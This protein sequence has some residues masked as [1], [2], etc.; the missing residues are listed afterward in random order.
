MAQAKH[1]K[2][3]ESKPTPRKVT[4]PVLHKGQPDFEYVYHGADGH[5]LY[6]SQYFSGKPETRQYKNGVWVKSKGPGSML[7]NLH[8]VAKAQTVLIVEDEQTVD[9]LNKALN[10]NPESSL[11]TNKIAVTCNW[12]GPGNRNWDDT[13]TYLSEKE[14]FILPF[15][16]SNEKDFFSQR[17]S[18]KV[19]KEIS[20]HVDAVIVE[21]LNRDGRK[22]KPR[23][24]AMANHL[25]NSV[26]SAIRSFA[27]NLFDPQRK[28][29]DS[30]EFLFIID[31]FEKEA[32]DDEI[33][34]VR[35]IINRLNKKYEFRYNSITM[36][37][38]FRKRGDDR[39]KPLDERAENTI[40]IDYNA[41]MRT[42]KLTDKTLSQFLNSEYIRQ[43][44]AFREYF[45]N[46]LPWREG[47]S[48]DYIEQLAATVITEED[49][50]LFY[51]MLRKWLIGVVATSLWKGRND[52]CLTF[53]G[54]QG[55]GKTSWLKRLTPPALQEYHNATRL[56]FSSKDRFYYLTSSFMIQLDELDQYRKDEISMLK[57]FMSATEAKFRPVFGRRLGIFPRSASFCA[58]TNLDEFLQDSTGARRYLVFKIKDVDFM[59]KI[60]MDLVYAQAYALFRAG[61][62][63]WLESDEVAEINERNEGFRSQT[64]EEE[65][66]LEKFAPAELT[67]PLR[68]FFTTTQ[69]LRQLNTDS[70]MIL[71]IKQLGRALYKHG[72]TKHTIGGSTKQWCV[73]K[74]FAD[75]Q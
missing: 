53:V 54:G 14:V 49:P 63:F 4:K 38:E 12:G 36:L 34:E 74:I 73:K 16:D 55:T 71:S 51:K 64:L 27:P 19:F 61:E 24:D 40:I 7:Y 17:W 31:N 35:L 13:F 10:I 60:N 1:T 3:S 22:F 45:I 43:Y 23:I 39:F 9:S 46:L 68:E 25:N 75:S 11:T 44:H 5:P 52:L 33:N 29:P 42:A 21:A 37:P 8:L 66:L 6:R 65:L 69:I 70:K 30:P 47:E 18:L 58:S 72:F 20:N 32:K 41:N 26:V 15:D 50:A 2:N 62:K 56:D 57:D 59:H 67:Y 48:E 28:I